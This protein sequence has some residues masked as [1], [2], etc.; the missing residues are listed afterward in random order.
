ME[1][2]KAFEVN[3][4][5]FDVEVVESQQPV[6]VVFWEEACYP[7]RAMDTVLDQLAEQYEGRVRIAHIDAQSNWQTARAYDVRNF[8]TALLFQH[9]RVTETIVGVEPGAVFQK[10]IDDV[11][12]GDWV[13]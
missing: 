4:Q 5:N 13:I 10:A 12:G 7:C 3:E 8:P 9:G 1:T 2:V 11:L 6:L